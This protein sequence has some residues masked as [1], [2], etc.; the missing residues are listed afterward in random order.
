MT[1]SRL[2][3]RANQIVV[4][5]LLGLAGVA[6]VLRVRQAFDMSSMTT[7]LGQVGSRM[8]KDMAAPLFMAM[9]LTIGRGITPEGY[10]LR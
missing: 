3:R 9:W 7:G 4:A 8:P 6:W 10:R 1:A 5:T 2:E